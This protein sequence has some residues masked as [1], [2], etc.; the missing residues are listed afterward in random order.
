MET[1]ED[2]EVG[3]D[4]GFCF[5]DDQRICNASCMAYLTFPKEAQE[6]NDQQQHC[7]LLV[8]EERKARHLVIIAKLLADQNTAGR[9][10]AADKKR[11]AAIPAVPAVSPFP[12][13]P[14]GL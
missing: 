4:S 3:I 7:A 12:K 8:F 1:D 10:A 9:K 14:E 13:P 11:E 2:N 6:L 5:K